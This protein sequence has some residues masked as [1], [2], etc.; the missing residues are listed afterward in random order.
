MR[1]FLNGRFVDEKDAVISFDD[2]G[3]L[4]ADAVY[5]VIHLYDG[6]PYRLKPHL[7]RLE[8]SLEGAMLPPVDLGMITRVIF[9][10]AG[11]EG[12]EVADTIIYIE[13]TRGA[14]PR[15]HMFPG[16]EVTPTIL[17]WCR[18]APPPA[19]ERLSNGISAITVSDDRWAKCW[20]KTVNLLPNVMA[21]ERARRA[22]AD[23]A[24]FVR[25]GMVLES[26]ASNLFIV[27]GDVLRTAPVTNYILPGI[28]RAALLE[29]A[30]SV[31]LQVREEPFSVEQLLAA[32]EVF[33]SG[34]TSEVLPVTTVDG[35]MLR[36]GQ[37]PVAVKLRE[38]L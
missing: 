16:P 1:V 32:D 20:I 31:G 28:T 33:L 2:R 10:L 34:T 7:D 26:T 37:G 3:F 14:A 5:E 25:D 21:K 38:A 18:P 35:K 11:Q 29:L 23:D 12:R 8:R 22:G 4:F 27:T 24:L 17:L 15:N 6:V 9:D 13:I 30:P 19:E 36:H